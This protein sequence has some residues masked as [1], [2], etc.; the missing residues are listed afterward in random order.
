[1]NIPAELSEAAQLDGA[2]PWQFMVQVL[3]SNQLECDWRTGRDS[4]RKQLEPI[5]MAVHCYSQT[6][7]SNDPSWSCIF[8]G[9]SETGD[10]YGP[11]MLGTVLASLPPLIVFIA[12]QKQFLKRFCT[13]TRQITNGISLT[14][15]SQPF[16]PE[17]KGE[18][19]KKHF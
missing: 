12:L 10:S 2:N 4:I 3:I 5:F 9:R 7:T 17:L 19:L 6:R 11:M 14:P 1:M 18:G 13:H 16:S 15:S 8:G